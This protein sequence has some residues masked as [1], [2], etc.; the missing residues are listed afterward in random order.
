MGDTIFIMKVASKISVWRG[1]FEEG[2]FREEFYL[3]G[4]SLEDVIEKMKE[5]VNKMGKSDEEMRIFLSLPANWFFYR[6]LKLP[7]AVGRKIEKVLAFEVEK[8]IPVDIDKVEVR[9]FSVKEDGDTIYLGTFAI[10]KDKLNSVLELLKNS[11]F[12]VDSVVPEPFLLYSAVRDYPGIYV[13]VDGTDNFVLVNGQEYLEIYNFIGSDEEDINFYLSL[14]SK[15]IEARWGV[16]PESVK[17]LKGDAFFLN[18]WMKVISSYG[19]YPQ[20]SR[21][22]FMSSVRATKWRRFYGTAGF[23]LLFLL[24]VNFIGGMVEYRNY[25]RKYEVKKNVIETIFRETFPEVKNIVDPV[26]QMKEMVNK[27]K[28]EESEKRGTAIDLLYILAEEVKKINGMRIEKF[29]YEGT[30]MRIE[31]VASSISDIDRL[32]RAFEERKFKEVNLVNTRKNP[33]GEFEF[34]IIVK[35]I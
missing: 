26:T 12:Y 6:F 17:V 19:D 16:K 33:K 7:K 24:F 10:M 15:S 27:L 18:G 4:T 20:F 29:A 35:L 28:L 23:V 1:Y 34:K 21:E 32:Q 2:R 8:E 5:E 14:L 11:G 30:S 13:K 9:H 3:D 25:K 31:G 22:E